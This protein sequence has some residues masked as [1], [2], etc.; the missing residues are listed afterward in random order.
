MVKKPAP[1]RTHDVST[2]VGI[3]FIASCTV[4]GMA[5][6]VIIPLATDK[7]GLLHLGGSDGRIE[8]LDATAA[9]MFGLLYALMG[10]LTGVL[11]A[12]NREWYKAAAGFPMV[13]LAIL[14][15]RAAT[16]LHIPFG[17]EVNIAALCLLPILST[18]ACLTL[19]DKVWERFQKPVR[20]GP[21]S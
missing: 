4:I 1:E 15:G 9:T 10:F 16:D 14:G 13:I 3:F 5:L 11:L 18:M 8:H 6:G 7:M 20:H 21:S 17:G 12:I 2:R 19:R